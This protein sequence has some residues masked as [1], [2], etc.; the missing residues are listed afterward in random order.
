M[1]VPL[2]HFIQ[3]YHES[4]RYLTPEVVKRTI[5]RGDFRVNDDGCGAFRYVWG[6]GVAYYFI[7]GYHEKGY[8]ILITG[9]PHVHHR[10]AALESGR[11]TDDEL[12]DIEALNARTQ[13][14]SR[15]DEWREIIN[16]VRQ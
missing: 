10:G 15:R 13:D 11:W 5:E 16:D 9:W 14:P 4:E 8:R 3:R 6:E 2:D 1:Y 12:D 7:V